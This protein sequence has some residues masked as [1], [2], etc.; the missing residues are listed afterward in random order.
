[1]SSGAHRL[2]DWPLSMATWD[3]METSAGA[4]PARAACSS[5]TSQASPVGSAT[6]STAMPVARVNS[7][8]MCLSNESLK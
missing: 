2:V 6:D 7:G 3:I 8:K 1:M 4:L 5:W